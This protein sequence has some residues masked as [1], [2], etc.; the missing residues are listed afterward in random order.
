MFVRIFPDV[1]FVISREHNVAHEFY[2][3][4]IEAFQRPPPPWERPVGAGE[5]GFF[6]RHMFPVGD[7]IP[8]WPT[9]RYG[10]ATWHH[11]VAKWR[12]LSRIL[13]VRHKEDKTDSIIRILKLKCFIIF[14]IYIKSS[15]LNLCARLIHW[16]TIWRLMSN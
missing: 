1:E 16:K 13:S 10:V 3:F 6:Y 15:Y 2:I 7:C 11:E 12:L 9:R 14:M 8:G 5:F 4:S